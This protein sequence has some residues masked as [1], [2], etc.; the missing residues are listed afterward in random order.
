M[1]DGEAAFNNL[2]PM[3]RL[4]WMGVLQLPLRETI[5]TLVVPTLISLLDAWAGARVIGKVMAPLA[6]EDPRYAA[7]FRRASLFIYLSGKTCFAA[8]T[9][10]WKHIGSM[11]NNIRDERYLLGVT[12]NNLNPEERR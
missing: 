8:G 10:L 7:L 9:M 2:D 11:H 3:P 5:Q 6:F 1:A 4:P 12:L